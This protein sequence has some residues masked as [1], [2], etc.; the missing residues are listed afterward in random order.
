MAAGDRVT[1]ILLEKLRVPR[2]DANSLASLPSRGFPFVNSSLYLP[3]RSVVS[4][5]EVS[6]MIGDVNFYLIASLDS[7][8]ADAKEG[9]FGLF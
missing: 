9:S 2:F 4:S 5:A 8:D 6:A 1:F 3:E 7:G